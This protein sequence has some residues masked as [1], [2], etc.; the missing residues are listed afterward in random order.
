MGPQQDQGNKTPVEAAVGKAGWGEVECLGLDP[1][2]PRTLQKGREESERKLK[3]LVFGETG[4]IPVRSMSYGTDGAGFE[5][6]LYHNQ[7]CKSG[8]NISNSLLSRL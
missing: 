8:L 2:L 4:D 5:I 1:W 6:L 7:I 3:H